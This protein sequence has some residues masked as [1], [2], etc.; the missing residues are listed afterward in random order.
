M[1]FRDGPRSR[2]LGLCKSADDFDG[3]M[4]K[5]GA[6]AAKHVSRELHRPRN[7]CCPSR[8]VQLARPKLQVLVVSPKSSN[9]A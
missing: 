5:V 6:T 3:S 2:S 4:F 7:V 1:C 9:L 8:L